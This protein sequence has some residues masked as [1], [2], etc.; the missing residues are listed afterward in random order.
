MCYLPL[1]VCCVTVGVGTVNQP[2]SHGSV[3]IFCCSTTGRADR[4]PAV[5]RV[6]GDQANSWTFTHPDIASYCKE[7]AS[8]PADEPRKEGVEVP[9]TRL[10]SRCPV[11]NLVALPREP[12]TVDS[13]IQGH[14]PSPGPRPP[15]T[16][17]RTPYC[18]STFSFNCLKQASSRS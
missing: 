8:L 2:T 1:C 12:I 7:V 9:H 16:R 3:R 14:A 6:F 17:V 4:L 11:P 13:V 5:S 15:R 10:L 18:F